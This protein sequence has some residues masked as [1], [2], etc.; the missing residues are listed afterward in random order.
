MMDNRTWFKQAKFGLMIHWGLYAVPA[1][2]WKGQRNDDLG[3]WIQAFYR[4]P[5]AEYE[6]L[7]EAFNP[8]L[9]DAEEWVRLAKDAGMQYIVITSKHHDGFALFKSEADPYN[10]VDATPFKRD[11]IAEFAAAC[12]K[13]GLKLGLYYSQDLDWHEPDGGGY[14]FP[15][16]HGNGHHVSWT[17][18][19]D[20][21]DASAK[22]YSRCFEKK[23]K[24]QVKEILTKY[25]DLCLIWFDTPCTINK[26]Q[27]A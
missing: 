26:E 5:K 1:G 25:G 14:N 19:W 17:N 12:K 11:I 4:I 10:V 23:I 15:A 7:A 2:E 18:N 3:E 22:D 20:Y 24:P 8:I 13:H 9:F 6:K 21:P 16:I 27:S